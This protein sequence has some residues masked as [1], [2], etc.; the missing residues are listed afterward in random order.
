[1]FL[2]VHLFYSFILIL[3]ISIIIAAADSTEQSIITTAILY[4]LWQLVGALLGHSSLIWYHFSLWFWRLFL[5]AAYALLLLQFYNSVFMQ[6]LL[7]MNEAPVANES[8]QEQ[9]CGYA[10]FALHVYYFLPRE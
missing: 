3:A 4:L 2:W 5:V 6:L 8:D 7:K 10:P 1:M 9:L